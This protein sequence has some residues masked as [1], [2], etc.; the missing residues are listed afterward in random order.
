MA[1]AAPLQVSLMWYLVE[2]R[3]EDEGLM[4]RG[5][6]CSSNVRRDGGEGVCRDS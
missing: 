5:K 1:R 6:S 4:R 2:L 3:L